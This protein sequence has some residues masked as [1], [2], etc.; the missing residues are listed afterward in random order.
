MNEKIGIQNFI[1]R[2]L[3]FVFWFTQRCLELVQIGH[4][5][6]KVLHGI[7][8]IFALGL[9]VAGKHLAVLGIVVKHPSPSSCKMLRKFIL[10]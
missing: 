8:R 9:S 2:M 4:G 5:R 6:V 1:E 7:Q 3:L 10:S